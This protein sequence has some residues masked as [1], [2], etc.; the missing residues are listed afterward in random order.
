M[1]KIVNKQVIQISKSSFINDVNAQLTKEEIA[2]KY[3]ITIAYASGI[4]KQI[5]EV[6]KLYLK[7]KRNIKPAW[8]LVDDIKI[9]VPTEMTV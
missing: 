5:N 9:N 7:F 1:T 2:K 3:N 6:D 8:I 4:L